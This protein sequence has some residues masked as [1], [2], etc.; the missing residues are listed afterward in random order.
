MADNPAAVHC[1]EGNTTV[2]SS[3]R[4][5]QLCLF[6]TRKGRAVYLKYLPELPFCLF[7]DRDHTLR[8][9]T[10]I[11]TPNGKLNLLSQCLSAAKSLPNTPLRAEIFTLF[12]DSGL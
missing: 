1:H 7:S 2:Y 5:D 11:D 8:A 10:T 6:V 4:L 3:Q 9:L 12:S